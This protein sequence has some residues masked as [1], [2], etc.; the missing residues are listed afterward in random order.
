MK[1]RNLA[2]TLAVDSQIR[3]P[4]SAG[5]LLKQIRD[6]ESVAPAFRDA[7][8]VKR[9]ERPK[10]VDMTV[11]GVATK[12]CVHKAM[13]GFVYAS[14]AVR[15]D[16]RIQENQ[17]ST[18]GSDSVSELDDIDYEAQRKRLDLIDIRHG[19]KLVERLLESE[20]PSRLIL[21]DTPLFLSRDMAPLGRNL[22][23]AREYESTCEAIRL[24]WRKYRGRLFPW[25]PD[26]PVLTAILA[27]RF[28][29]VVSIARQDLRSVEGRKHILQ[30]DGFDGTKINSL[31]ALDDQLAGI[32]DI[33][34][35]HGILGAF[36]RTIGFRLMEKRFRMEPGEAVG[37]GVIGFHL[38]GGQSSSIQMV[39]MAGEEDDWNKE[40]LDA[41][42]WKLMV[43]DIQNGR[44]GSPIPQLLGRQQLAM[45]DEF[46]RYYCRGL[47][48]AIKKNEVEEI[49]LSGFEE[50]F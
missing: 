4:G 24:F 45:L 30:S 36:T 5:R 32:G 47:S 7:G 16:M 42:A 50:D 37:P 28:S 43:L 35:I 8:L 31:A 26:G 1:G 33:R 23:H 6:I 22:K 10:V 46:A 15:T 11:S 3:L 21:L 12:S 38:R 14:G 41:V 44:G 20:N 17:L 34:F 18:S 2:Q 25:N 13:G 29:A 19:Y 27:E 40:Q 39:Q 9:V 49:W 48:D